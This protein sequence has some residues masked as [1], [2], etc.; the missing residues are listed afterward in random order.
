M[1]QVLGALGLEMLNLVILVTAETEGR[2][3]EQMARS[4]MVRDPALHSL[5]KD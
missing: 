1:E 5:A 3:E 2:A 4:F